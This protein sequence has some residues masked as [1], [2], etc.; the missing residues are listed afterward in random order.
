M[1]LSTV[2]KKGNPQ[3]SVVVYE[4]DGYAL[5]FTTGKNTLKGKNMRNNNNVSVTIPFM[6]NLLHKFIPAPPA[7]LHFKAKVE[8]LEREDEEIQTNLAKVLKYEEKAGIS[9]ETI[10]IKLTPSKKI[11]TYGVGI[12]LLEMRFPEKARNL[13]IME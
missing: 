2:N 6:K 13:I 11:A 8:I 1:V 10:Y 9:A 7:E 12:K 5:Y 4:S 3:S